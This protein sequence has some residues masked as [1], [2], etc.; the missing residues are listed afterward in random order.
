MR[1][2]TALAAALLALALAGCGEDDEGSAPPPPPVAEE[3]ADELP[4]LPRGWQAEVNRAGGFAFGRPPG[5]R[6]SRGPAVTLTAPDELVV[7][8][9]SA[10]RTADAL[11][12]APG[13]FA[14]QTA[15]ALGGYRRPVEPSRPRPFRHPY[16][17]VEVRGTGVAT[18]SG[19]RQDVRV[20]VLR[21]D[22]TAVVTA[23]VAA[24]AERDSAAELRQALEAL[25]TLRTRPVS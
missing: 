4:D 10:D 20:V 22:R 6:A 18:R 25:G 7:A 2:R 9:I 14:E 11:A 17:A 5:W 16:D 24:N 1:A 21:N 15:S 13:E 3:R 23:V 8:T 19:V 12:L